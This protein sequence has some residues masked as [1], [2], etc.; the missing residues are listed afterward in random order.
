MYCVTGGQHLTVN[1]DLYGLGVCNPACWMSA[2]TYYLFT[3]LKTLHILLDCGQHSLLEI[4]SADLLDTLKNLM[5][6][7][8]RMVVSMNSVETIWIFSLLDVGMSLPCLG[9]LLCVF[10]TDISQLHKEVAADDRCW[11][12]S[13]LWPHRYTG[14]ITS[15]SAFTRARNNRFDGRIENQRGSIRLWSRRSVVHPWAHC[16]AYNTVSQKTVQICFC[17]NFV[18]FPPV[19]IF[20]TER[21]QIG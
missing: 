7:L 14:S 21:W 9:N 12:D 5:L 18:K 16:T 3:D 13:Y 10:C 11:A 15:R 19:L 20:F 17:H 2:K 4:I 6:Y 1:K 8:Y